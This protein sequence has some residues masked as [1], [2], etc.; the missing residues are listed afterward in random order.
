M[1]KPIAVQ[2]RDGVNLTLLGGVMRGRDFD[3]R[4]AQSMEIHNLL[5]INTR[6][7]DSPRDEIHRST[8]PRN[9]TNSVSTSENHD[10]VPSALR[11]DVTGAPELW[12]RW[13]TAIPTPR[14]GQTSAEKGSGTIVPPPSTYVSTLQHALTPA[15]DH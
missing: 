3:E 14:R 10:I 6:D 4:A 2:N 12:P 15:K 7:Q 11:S 9:N 1:G 8:R 5:G 13:T